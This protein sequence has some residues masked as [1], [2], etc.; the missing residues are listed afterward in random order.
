MMLF[1]DA[2]DRPWTLHGGRVSAYWY[3][4]LLFLYSPLALVVVVVWG[5][6]I[7]T[8]TIVFVPCH[9]QSAHIRRIVLQR[10]YIGMLDNF[11]ASFNRL[12]HDFMASLK[13]ETHA[14]YHMHLANLCTR[15]DFNG[16]YAGLTTST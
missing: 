16:F 13:D 9:S 2:V 8:L 12:V 15:L 10:S 11:H 14:E 7:I 6:Q 1:V 5:L 3:V 4:R